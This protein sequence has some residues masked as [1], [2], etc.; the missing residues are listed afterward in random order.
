MNTSVPSISI[1]NQLLMKKEKL[2]TLFKTLKKLMDE[3]SIDIRTDGEPDIIDATP[4]IDN[5]HI[6]VRFN[7]GGD[8]CKLLAPLG[9]RSSKTQ[10]VWHP[11]AKLGGAKQHITEPAPEVPPVAPPKPGGERGLRTFPDDVV[12]RG[13]TDYRSLVRESIK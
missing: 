11:N 5:N 6:V 12:E 9:G 13:D 7:C 2:G 10:I 4:D 8:P 3:K 1:Y